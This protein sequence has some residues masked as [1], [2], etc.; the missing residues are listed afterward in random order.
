MQIG[1][2][3]MQSRKMDR[4]KEDKKRELTSILREMKDPRVHNSIISVVRVEVSNDLSICKVYVSSI[5]GIEKA[6]EAVEGLKSASGYIKREIGNRLSLR[7]IP[8]M[9][10]KATDSI[11]YSANIA[12]ILNK[13]DLK[14]DK[15]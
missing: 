15:K 10:F 5:D 9:I 13:I 7:H 2:I 1:G 8:S 6:K 3:K 4:V 11:E 14:D 12:K